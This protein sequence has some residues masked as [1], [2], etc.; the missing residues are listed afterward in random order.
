MS[1]NRNISGG[2]E[3]DAFLQQVSAK[4]E[5][6][7]MRSA[8][9]AGANVFKDAAKSRVPV[10]LGALRRSI[11]V[12]TGYKKGRVSASVKAGNKKAWY[13]QFVEFG[14]APHVIEAKRASALA[15]GGTVTQRVQHPGARPH[16]F[17][18]PAMDV[19]ADAAI[20]AIGT[21]IRKRLTVEG[22][23]VPAPEDR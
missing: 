13:W 9:R 8:L 15:F 19:Q 20:H 18:R 2:A 10:E 12:N 4:V 22:L 11:R 1:N 17:L 3:L 16:P 14:T 7:I 5:K 6:N 21:Q 23:N